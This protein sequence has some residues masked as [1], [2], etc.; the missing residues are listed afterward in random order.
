MS[1]MHQINDDDL[2]ELEKTLP[3]LQDCLFPELA[4]NE[5]AAPRIRKM[6]G[7]VKRVLSDVRWGYGP[8]TEVIVIKGDEE[9][10]S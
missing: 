8:P 6:L 5:A 7:A 10:S 3:L 4:R 2:A 1:R 9:V